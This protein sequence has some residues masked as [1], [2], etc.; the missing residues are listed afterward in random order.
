MIVVVSSHWHQHGKYLLAN[1]SQV[2]IQFRE[3]DIVCLQIVDQYFDS[4][5]Y[6]A[7][8]LVA[9]KIV[10]TLKHF[11]WVWRN[12]QCT[13][14]AFIVICKN[15]FTWWQILTLMTFTSPF[16]VSAMTASSSSDTTLTLV[17]MAN[18]SSKSRASPHFLAL[19]PSEQIVVRA[20]ITSS[21][22]GRHDSWSTECRNGITTYKK[23]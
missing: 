16:I 8:G 15:C 12:G 11:V 10:C 4:T 13:C 17:F 9:K 18:R 14:I 21:R 1:S 20:L 23:N 2:D 7:R 22:I 19:R 6:D 3:F 5:N